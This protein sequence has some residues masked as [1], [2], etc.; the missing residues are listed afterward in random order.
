MTTGVNSIARRTR[1][2][3]LEDHRLAGLEPAQRG[4]VADRPCGDRTRL[5]PTCAATAMRSSARRR[6]RPGRTA[7][8]TPACR[9]G[10]ANRTVVLV[11]DQRHGEPVQ[12]V[13]QQRGVAAAGSSGPGRGSA[14]PPARRRRV[15]LGHP[16]PAMA[17]Q[18]SEQVGPQELLDAIGSHSG[19]GQVSTRRRTR[20]AAMIAMARRAVHA[21]GPRHPLICPPGQDEGRAVVDV[22][23]WSRSSPCRACHLQRQRAVSVAQLTASRSPTR[24]TFPDQGLRV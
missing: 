13:G 2:A 3:R 16:L 18:V 22:E 1:R 6:S 23:C 11:E 14:N 7:A 9:A 5:G 19:S 24:P 15:P 21:A 10:A 20:I 4:Q 12:Q 17:V 8:S